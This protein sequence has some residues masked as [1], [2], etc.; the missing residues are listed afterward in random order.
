MSNLDLVHIR[1]S[2]NQLSLKERILTTEKPLWS[3]L[4]G[5]VP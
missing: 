3:F 2:E 4:A 1:K 5:I